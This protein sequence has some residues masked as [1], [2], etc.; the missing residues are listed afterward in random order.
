MKKIFTIIILF[1]IS[2]ITRAQTGV[3][4]PQLAGFDTAMMNLMN[5]YGV[6]GG[7]L[8]I[9]YQG[10]LVYNRGFGY[11]DTVA[12]SLVE[13]NSVFRLA[14]VSKPITAVAIMKL[15]ENG[16]INLDAKVFGPSGILNDAAYQNILDPRVNDITVRE[17][18][19]HGGGW[20]RDISG[21]PMFNSYTISVAMGVNPPAG[22]VSVISYVLANK[23]LDFTPGTEY[24]YSNFG[25][26]VLGRVIEKITGQNYEDY[27]LNTII[28]PLGITDMHLGHNLMADQLPNEVNYYDYPG[29]LLTN[30]V[31][32][33]TTQV[34]WPY[35]GFN[36]EA[37]DAHGGW[38]ASGED[39]CRL[40]CA[41]DKF[42]TRPDILLPATIDTMITPSAH[43]STYACGIAVNTYNNWWH[44]GTLMGTCTEIVRAGNFALN[45]SLLFNTRN[46]ISDPLETAIDNIVWSVVGSI[47]SW[48]THNLFT[49]IEEAPG[50]ILFDVYPN[51]ASDKLS[52]AI[53]ETAS[54]TEV[55]ILDVIGKVLYSSNVERNSYKEVTI[56]THNLADG[57]YFVQISSGNKNGIKKFIVN[58]NR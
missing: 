43:N 57:I 48:P 5:Q 8:A 54:T 11:A 12:H 42:P 40:L 26:C 31:Y 23:M 6:P 39:M 33:N 32:D 4:V 45:W 34:P 24:Q 58:H 47:T 38:V 1:I 28:H 35:A 29:A 52:I 19:Q 30:S 10:R 53:S 22:P 21:D 18:L 16:L 55:K 3:Y 20:N 36:I 7:Q 37:M 9:T 50:N 51:P 56:D 2:F 49:G 15:F 27:M 13:P 41:I 46:A 44:S 25:F 14:S 17:L